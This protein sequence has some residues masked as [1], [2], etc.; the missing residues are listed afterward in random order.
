MTVTPAGAGAWIQGAATCTARATSC[1]L[2][3]FLF[4]EK[5]RETFNVQILCAFSEL[6][7]VRDLDKFPD[8]N[9]K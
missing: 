9:R 2:V 5:L 6:M 8:A 1:H 7:S 3:G 4:K